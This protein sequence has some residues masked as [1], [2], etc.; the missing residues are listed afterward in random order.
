MLSSGDIVNANPT[1]HPDLWRALKGGSGN[2]GIVT[3]FDLATIPQDEIWGGTLVNEISSL[4][5]VLDAF[6]GIAGAS[7]YDEYTSLVTSLVFNSPSNSWVITNLA[8]Y[9]KPI[10]N[11]PVYEPLLA[12]QPQLQNTLSVT[13]MST[14]TNEGSSPPV[15]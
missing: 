9:T 6:A 5:E 13:N 14:L 10:E 4:P 1:S 3:R 12:V 8:T 2:F 15:L 11:P 7:D